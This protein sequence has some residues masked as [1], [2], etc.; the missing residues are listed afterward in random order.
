MGTY[1]YI[2]SAA[3]AVLVAWILYRANATCDAVLIE[4]SKQAALMPK[5]VPYYCKNCGFIG[6]PE[7]YRP[8]SVFLEVVLFL[9]FILPWII[10]RAVRLSKKYDGCPKCGAPNMIPADSPMS[11]VAAQYRQELT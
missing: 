11:P 3:F 8:G 1:G 4:Q 5:P 2:G 10:Y 6:P 9:C 7:T